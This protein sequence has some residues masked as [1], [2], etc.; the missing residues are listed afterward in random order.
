[1]LRLPQEICFWWSASSSHVP[2]VCFQRVTWGFALS[3]YYDDRGA[4]PANIDPA[5]RSRV[6]WL[7]NGHLNH[8]R[9]IVHSR[10][11]LSSDCLRG[12]RHR[13]LCG[14]L[15]RH[16]ALS[17]PRLLP[18]HMGPWGMF[19]MGVISLG[20]AWTTITG[21]SVY[22]LI[23]Y[24]TAG[25]A[26]FVLAINQWRKFAGSPNFQWGLALVVPMVAATSAAQLGFIT[27]GRI[28]FIFVWIIGV[29]V[30]LYVY[31][32]LMRGRAN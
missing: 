2:A 8:C 4:Y 6:D 18:E 9:V 12:A 32:A 5:R 28:G 25:L 24:L 15:L 19:A 31:L 13:H 21:D 27:L 29:P 14:H 20:T 30:F 16:S 3:R 23:T 17:H 26:G 22:Q 1:S 7:I 11:Q 10:R